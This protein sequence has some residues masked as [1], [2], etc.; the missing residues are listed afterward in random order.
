MNLLFP[1]SDPETSEIC[2]RESIGSIIWFWYF[3]ELKDELEGFLNLGFLGESIT[4]DSF[5]HLEWCE[6][7]H[8][9]A[10]G[11]ERMYDD[12]AGLCDID[13]IG[14]IAQEE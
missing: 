8:L 2:Y 5:L 10:R 1:L 7:D 12:S 14:H 11:R 13:T 4:C 3:R 9:D 6:L